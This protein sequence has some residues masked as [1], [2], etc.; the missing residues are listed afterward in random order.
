[1]SEEMIIRH[2]SP[3]L[4]GIKTGNMF[5][6]A[7]FSRKELFNDIRNINKRLFKKGIR[8]IPL[9]IDDESALIY[10]YRPAKLKEDLKQADVI[11]LL[12]QL[13][14]SLNKPEHCVAELVLRMRTQE[15]FPHEVGLFLGYP[16]EDVSGFIDN[17][18]KNSKCIG[19]WKVYGNKEAAQRKFDLYKKCTDILSEQYAL[20][21]AIERLTV[22]G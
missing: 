8:V 1:M 10:I 12:E 20:G 16:P 19:C 3:T 22:A 15:K 6:C 2:C 4:A 17:E 9:R 21:K 7:Y 18:A 14:Y 5:R 11:S 13:G